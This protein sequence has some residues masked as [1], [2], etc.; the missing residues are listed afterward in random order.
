VEYRITQLSWTSQLPTTSQHHSPTTQLLPRNHTNIRIHTNPPPPNT[1]PTQTRTLTMERGFSWYFGSTSL[2]ASA[3]IC[4]DPVARKWEIVPRNLA[5][6]HTVNQGILFVSL[7]NNDGLRDQT[8]TELRHTSSRYTDTST[9]CSL[10]SS[11][12]IDRY[13]LIKQGLTSH[14]THYRSYRGQ[15]F[16]DWWPNKHC[17]ITEG[18]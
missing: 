2:A 6:P 13:R 7:L 16:T 18:R 17:Q 14:Q 11:Y 15:V 12:T 1:S 10:A 8:C 9:L 4:K 5:T 3:F